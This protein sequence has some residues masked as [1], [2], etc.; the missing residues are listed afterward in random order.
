MDGHVAFGEIIFAQ[1]QFTK[2][3]QRRDMGGIKEECQPF[4]IPRS[5]RHNE[6]PRRAK[7]TGQF[8]Q[9]M[10][11]FVHLLQGDQIET[12]ANVGD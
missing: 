4:L 6:I 9:R 11:V 12:A 3:A 1:C 8:S 5:V 7:A 10:P 2:Q